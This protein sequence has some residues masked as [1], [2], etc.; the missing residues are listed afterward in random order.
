MK[1]LLLL[2]LMVDIAAAATV[3]DQGKIDRFYVNKNGN[4]GVTLLEGAPNA[5]NVHSC[6]SNK[7]LGLNKENNETIVSTLLTAKASNK[8]VLI[9]TDG[10]FSSNWI[11]ILA[12]EIV[13]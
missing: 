3:T 9:Y 7:K 11:G 1:K 5:E 4:V 10:C 2:L 8:T 12:V 13:E 6:G